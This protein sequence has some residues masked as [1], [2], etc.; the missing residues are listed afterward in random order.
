MILFSLFAQIGKEHVGLTQR[1]TAV[2]I[3]KWRDL[4]RFTQHFVPMF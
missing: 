4:T 3:C 1:T 2:F